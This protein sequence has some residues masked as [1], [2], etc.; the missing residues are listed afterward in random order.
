MWVLSLLFDVLALVALLLTAA[1]RWGRSKA[2]PSILW[3]IALIV[4]VGV[5]PFP[6]GAPLWRIIMEAIR[7]AR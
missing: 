4:V 3:W 1:E 6:S 5:F 2:A 7:H